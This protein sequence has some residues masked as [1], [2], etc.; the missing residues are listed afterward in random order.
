M[1][2]QLSLFVA[3]LATLFITLAA[4]AQG[5]W[6]WAHYWSGGDGSY[7]DYYNQITNTAFDEEGNIYVYGTM[8]GDAI[9]DGVTFQFTTNPRVLSKNDRTILLA[10][11]D[12][13]GNI[14]WHK[15]MKSDNEAASPRWM[16]VRN[17]KVFVAV[18][19]GFYGEQSDSWLYYWDTLIT[20]TQI[21]ALPQEL[22]KPPFQAFSRWTCLA[23]FD[24]DGNLLKDH[25]LQAYSRESVF[26]GSNWLRF[27][28][29]L[30]SFAGTEVTPAHV[31]EDGNFYIF[32]PIQYA[33]V[34]ERPYTIVVDDDPD[35]TY[36][37]YLPGNTDSS[38]IQSVIN[39]AML[40]K[41]SPTGELLYAKMLVDHTDGIAPSY[42]S[43]DS[44]NRY[45][46]TYFKGLS[47]DEDDNMYL[48]GYV[49]LAD[50]L[51][52]LGG[53]LHNYPVHI[54]WD[55]VHHLTINDISSA[56]QCSFI[57]KY[58]ISGNVIWCNQLYSR[59]TQNPNNGFAFGNWFRNNCY[60]ENVYVLGGAAYNN[61][62]AAMIY[63]DDESNLLQRFQDEITD[64]CFFVKYD[65]N[66]GEY[67]N[68][69]IVPSA[70]ATTSLTPAIVNNRVFA[71]SRYQT[72]GYGYL[73][74]EWRNDGTFIKADTISSNNTIEMIRSIGSVINENGYIT[75]SITATS[76]VNFSNNVSANCPS[77][78]SSAVFALYHNPEFTQPFVPDDSVGIDEYYQNREREIYLYPNPTDGQTTVCGY[79][80]GYRSIELLDL[81]GRRLATLLDS[82]HGTDVPE[83]DLSPY[84]SG[85]YLVK[86][87]FERG[88]S[89][90]RKVVRR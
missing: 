19:C 6:K 32:T 46:Y 44:I 74:S 31:D 50:C 1:K 87:N 42:L 37:L 39:N 8:G 79:M 73:L 4:S 66:T 41:F 76:S 40:Y 23:Q 56:E 63:F 80:Y 81:Q 77:G 82:P 58:D 65:K 14:L 53:E 57:V 7:G 5:E 45:F 3:T 48:T 22:Q 85:T 60:D 20:R 12:T 67:V 25:F 9:F 30:C 70:N 35:K 52:G 18:D 33:G 34:E 49:N 17:N 11:F 29:S 55:S 89:V 75:L 43:S 62:E 13:L 47:F 10:K 72:I 51:Y 21:N 64:I 16:E 78:Q 24:L 90:V 71:M 36:N 68:H 86:I 27:N 84:P 61:D 59:G 28:Y 83:I 38:N 2:N 69:G 15:E 54:W 26:N 88:V